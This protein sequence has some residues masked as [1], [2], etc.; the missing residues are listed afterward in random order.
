MLRR[1]TLKEENRYG[2][3]EN[4]FRVKSAGRGAV[5]TYRSN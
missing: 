4:D 3:P 2:A 1:S 5:A